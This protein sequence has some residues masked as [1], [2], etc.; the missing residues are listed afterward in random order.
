MQQWRE[1]MLKPSKATGSFLTHGMGQ[2]PNLQPGDLDSEKQLTTATR[3]ASK[4]EC[5]R[6]Y[7][8]LAQPK[9]RI[10]DFNEISF[11]SELTSLNF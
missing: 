10:A 5:L 6:W 4:D 9:S 7:I 2:L 11:C 1:G 3:V 8:D